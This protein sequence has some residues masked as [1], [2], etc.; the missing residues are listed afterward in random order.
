MLTSFTGNHKRM[1]LSLR[2]AKAVYLFMNRFETLRRRQSFSAC[3]CYV[4]A[5]QSLISLHSSHTSLSV[6]QIIILISRH[7]D[8]I[9][10]F[11]LFCSFDKLLRD[12]STHR[13]NAVPYQHTFYAIMMIIV[14][15]T[16]E[17]KASV[18]KTVFLV[19]ATLCIDVL[20]HSYSDKWANF[21]LATKPKFSIKHEASDLF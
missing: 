18:N 11:F 19:L 17:L 5:F 14:L 15:V 4:S 12:V 13:N 2:S 8:L 3:S 10:N 1:V 7:H 20:S 16:Y 21:S 9:F 6:Y